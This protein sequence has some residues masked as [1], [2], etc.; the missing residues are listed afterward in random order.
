MLPVFLLNGWKKAA[1]TFSLE[2]VCLDR[3]WNATVPE[4][5]AKALRLQSNFSVKQYSH[6]N[7]VILIG[8]NDVCLHACVLLNGQELTGRLI[9]ALVINIEVKKGVCV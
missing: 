6:Q 7:N 3:Y 1:I 8:A 9:Y 5:K 2:S 4:R